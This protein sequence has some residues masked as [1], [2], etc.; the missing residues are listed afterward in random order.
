MAILH[1]T[2]D[3][4]LSCS[5]LLQA[6]LI[7][8]VVQ[9]IIAN[10]AISRDMWYFHFHLICIGGCAYLRANMVEQWYWHFMV[11]VFWTRLEDTYSTHLVNGEQQKDQ[12]MKNRP[13]LISYTHF[14][15]QMLKKSGDTHTRRTRIAINYC[16]IT[17]QKSMHF[18]RKTTWFSVISFACLLLSWKVAE[19]I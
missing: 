4:T 14:Q 10:D 6:Y 3:Y 19:T 17:N 12:R 11:F 1:Y 5:M 2:P 13:S 8:K 16:D 7:S 15:S 9:A 18:C